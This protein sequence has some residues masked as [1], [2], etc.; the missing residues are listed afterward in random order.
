LT[1]RR[2]VAHAA[3]HVYR[4]QILVGPLNHVLKVIF[5]R[6][7]PDYDGTIEI[8]GLSYPSGHAAGAA[9]VANILLVV[10]WPVLTR[11]GRLRLVVLSIVGVAVVGYSRVALGAH[12]ASDVIAGWCV[13]I[14]W[15]LLL[16]VVLRVWL[17]LSGR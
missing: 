17:G 11:A 2:Y 8:Y 16:A 4:R 12:F 3:E 10:F 13:G 5:G 14:A 9:A 6:P 1:S 7:R 15:V